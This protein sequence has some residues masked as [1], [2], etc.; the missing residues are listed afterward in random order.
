MLYV[1]PQ[2]QNIFIQQIV[3]K[4]L[5][6]VSSQNLDIPTVLTTCFHWNK[7]LL[8]TLMGL[9]LWVVNPMVGI[10]WCVEASNFL[11][12]RL[13][14]SCL[15]NSVL[16]LEKCLWNG[17]YHCAKFSDQYKYQTNNFWFITMR[18]YWI[19]STSTDILKC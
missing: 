17:F 8:S 16:K 9:V 15:Q 11:C 4:H 18:I 5:L 7:A 1:S 10:E 3:V 2:N 12:H 13:M 6:C 14:L 19:D